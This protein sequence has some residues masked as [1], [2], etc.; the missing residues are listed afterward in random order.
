MREV[1]R[2][3]VVVPP[4]FVRA[5][6]RQVT[7]K[8]R[9]LL[10]TPRIGRLIAQ[11]PSSGAN[12]GAQLQTVKLLADTSADGKQAKDRQLQ[13]HNNVDRSGHRSITKCNE[14]YGDL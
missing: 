10:H 5:T 14:V 13:P 4:A 2:G 12:K 9:M 7:P 3:M 8:H 6:S 1:L 11:N